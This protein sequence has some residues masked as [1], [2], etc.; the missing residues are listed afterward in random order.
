VGSFFLNQRYQKRINEVF[1]DIC[2]M[3]ATEKEAFHAYLKDADWLLTWQFRSELY[4][5]TP[6]LAAVFTP[7]AGKDWVPHDLSNRVKR[8][9]S[10][11]ASW[12]F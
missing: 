6:K 4:G 9:R 7:T 12:R 3:E 11:D 5:Q 10:P 2:L 8:S 1:L